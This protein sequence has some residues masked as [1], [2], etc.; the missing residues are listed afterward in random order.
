LVEDDPPADFEA[1]APADTIYDDVEQAEIAEPSSRPQSMRDYLTLER[2][3]EMST[4]ER[5]R[6]LARAGDSKFNSQGGN[7]NIEWALWSWNPV[8]GCEHNCPYCYARDIAERFY[9]QKF[10]PSLWPARLKAPQNTTYPN[11]KISAE[12]GD[13][14]KRRGLGNVFTCS[15]ADLF[16][17]WVPTEWIEAV[18]EA[19]RAAPQW[20]FLFLTKFPIRM[21][22]FDFPKNAWVGT[23]VD[24]Q[25]RVANAEKAFRKVKAGVKWLSIE[26]LIEPLKFSDLSAFQ[27]LVIG[28]ASASSQTP[29]WVPPLRWVVD[30][31]DAAARAGVPFYEKS[32]LGA[33]SNR[34]RQYPGD[35]PHSEQYLAPAQLRYLPSK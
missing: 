34:V 4:S 13:S 35:A 33:R 7:D 32:N 26:P 20:N 31:E 19:V 27:W 23:T 10:V 22:E 2:W 28:G 1:E 17:R 14:W 12:P 29:E 5:K 24:C 6:E 16:G 9:E 18:L 25:A 3:S 21:A 15:M 11:D 30:L 8:T